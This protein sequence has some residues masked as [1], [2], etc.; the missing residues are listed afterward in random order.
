VSEHAHLADRFDGLWRTKETA[1]DV[2]AFLTAQSAIT[3]RERVDVLLIDQAHRWRTGDPIPAEIYLEKFP[4]VAADPELK[5]DLVF[6]EFRRA[7]P[8][9]SNPPER[10]RFIARFPDLREA[11][12]RQAEVKDWCED[13][14]N[15]AGDG[16]GRG[17]AT[18]HPDVV[19]SPPDQP[20][21]QGL[22]SGL[23][24]EDYQLKNQIGR[25]GMGEVYR[26]VHR[27][28]GREVALKVIA[29]PYLSSEQ[30]RARFYREM[31]AVGK[32]DHPHLVR[33]F[34]ARQVGQRHILVMELL[35][36][37]NLRVLIDR[38]GPLSVAD[39]CAMIRQAAE[40]LQH[41][42]EQGVV[43]RDLKPS[44]L[45]LIRGGIIKV[46]D[47]GLARLQEGEA[48]GLTPYHLAM[49]TPDYVA[50]EQTADPR[51]AS[52]RSDLYSLGCTLYHL[53]AGRPPHRQA[54]IAPSRQRRPELPEG[55]VGLLDLMLAKD[56]MKR[57][58]SAAEVA[59]SLGSWCVGADLLGLLDRALHSDPPGSSSRAAI[60]NTGGDGA[61][62][63]AGPMALPSTAASPRGGEGFPTVP[64]SGP[65]SGRA[66]HRR[67]SMLLLA[68]AAVLLLGL[69]AAWRFVSPRGPLKVTSL[70]VH[71]YRQQ[72]HDRLDDLDLI[73]P[74][75]EAVRVRDHV[76]VEVQLS[77]P[78][79]AYL[80]ALNTDG[81]VQLGLPESEAQPP[82]RTDR[83][84]LYPSRVDYFTLTEG[85]GVQAF[86]VVA[87]LRPL[88]A[89]RDWSPVL[90]AMNWGHTEAAGVWRY[91]GEQFDDG[92][93]G[94]KTRLVPEPFEATCL[95]LKGRTEVEAIQAIAFPVLPAEGK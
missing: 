46:L 40:G 28:L 18:V 72:G 49:G 62:D 38:V 57:P 9:C 13:M 50:P 12:L 60:V 66:G 47:L 19:A 34:D 41:A 51:A 20:S 68:M 23:N 1:P 52:P 85:P 16:S 82:P 11:L 36:G 26:A 63:V 87:S 35:D 95:Y 29:P 75:G 39:A 45:M 7:L 91:D 3:P 73:G 64:G 70:S 5:L 79:H 22:A 33:A 78:A 32:L 4:E 14:G 56:P 2:F 94:I 24:L 76:R 53:L 10:E 55:L 58:S 69:P 81:S 54:P 65:D 83:L 15:G 37:L 21:S 48:D 17:D 77:D 92:T 43:H 93:R 67:R 31:R 88:P 6:G 27:R 61:A 89:Y 84:V 25:G 42:H 59:E 80:L 30:V 90:A 86:V 44:N 71:H 8:R 74:G